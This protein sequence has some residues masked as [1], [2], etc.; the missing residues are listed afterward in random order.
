MSVSKTTVKFEQINV[1]DITCTELVDMKSNEQAIL[2]LKLK[3]AYLNYKHPNGKPREPLQVLFPW[4]DLNSHGVAKEG[5]KYYKDTLQI[6]LTDKNVLAKLKEMDAYFDSD[7]FKKK[8]LKKIN[9]EN[10]K[11][12]SKKPVDFTYTPLVRDGFTSET[13][14]EYPESLIVKLD[15][16]LEPKFYEMTD[17]KSQQKPL[18]A[19][20]Q[21]DI[22]AF[23]PYRSRIRPIVRF[24]SFQGSNSKWTVVSKLVGCN[25]IPCNEAV[26]KM[27]SN[28]DLLSDDENDNQSQR[29]IKPAESKKQEQ[30]DKQ[31][32]EVKSQ[33]EQDESTK[34]PSKTI[35]QAQPTKAT[36]ATVTSDDDDDDKKPVNNKKQPVK[37]NLNKDDESDDD[38]TIKNQAK[39]QQA[40]SKAQAQQND[41]DGSDDEEV[42]VKKPQPT[43]GGKS[44]VANN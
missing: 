34:A 27:I 17:E 30:D 8:I 2:D 24:C 39:K 23:I 5:V 42:V 33:G 40:K 26:S 44:R 28:C 20:S 15:L 36:V 21:A 35:K 12:K 19:T 7:E 16:K 22:R 32:A 13:G 38:E 29:L 11:K 3:T 37:Q 10:D 43:K 18:V 31:V 9:E 14:N 41:T 6:P 1:A 4:T 25:I